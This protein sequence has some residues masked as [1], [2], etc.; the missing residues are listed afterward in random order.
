[1]RDCQPVAE[2]REFHVG[3]PFATRENRPVTRLP[4]LESTIK[5]LYGTATICAYP[6]C[7]EPLLR[8]INGVE[9][10]VL[11]SRIAHIAAASERG[12][13]CDL[14]PAGHGVQQR[15]YPAVSG[16]GQVS[17]SARSAPAPGRG[18]GPP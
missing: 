3:P 15:R 16:R 10:P 9:T 11:N 2:S 18:F 12:P 7:P 4:V 6:V 1:M 8:W 17:P 13:R 14:R 5:Q